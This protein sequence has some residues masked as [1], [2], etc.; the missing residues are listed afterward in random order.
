MSVKDKAVHEYLLGR[1]YWMERTRG[2]SKS[3]QVEKLEKAIKHFDQAIKFDEKY[4]RAYS[5]LADV[6]LILPFLSNKHKENEDV[7]VK[8]ARKAVKDAKKHNENLAEV[9]TSSGHLMEFYD[10]DYIEAEKE[11]KRAIKLNE[12]YAPAHYRYSYLLT[13]L[14][15]LPASITSAEKSVKLEPNSAF[16]QVELGCLFTF[17]KDYDAAIKNMSMRLYWTHAIQMHGFG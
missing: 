1:Y 4:A 7:Y 15:K 13:Q 10:E 17:K 8:K 14:G 16:Y 9:R 11:Y 5:G 6:Y 12:M 3:T 2:N